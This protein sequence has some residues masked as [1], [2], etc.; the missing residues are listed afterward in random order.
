MKARFL[1]SVSVLIVLAAIADKG[2]GYGWYPPPP[3]PPSAPSNL[4][5]TA[6]SSNQINLN[7]TD[8]SNN[9]ICF[10]IWRKIGSGG[11]W[12]WL[13]TVGANVHSYS[14]MNL[15]PSTTYY[16]KVRAYNYGGYSAYSNEANATT[17]NAPPVA[18]LS[19][20]PNAATVGWSVLLNGSAS[21]DPGGSITK[22]EWDFSYDSNTF[23]CDY[24]ETSSYHPDGIFDGKTHHA[25]DTCGYH[26]VML[27]VTDDVNSYG[28]CTAVAY[29]V[30][31]Y[32]VSQDGNDNNNG[33]SWDSA[34]ATIQHGI[35]SADSYDIV[36]VN[37][38]TYYE[39]V[40]FN[41]VRCT[42]TSIDPNNRN[43]VDATII[44]ANDSDANAVTFNSSEMQNSVLKGFTITGA[45]RGIYCE[46]SSPVIS[47]CIIRDN[48]TNG[49][50]G[51][52]CN[53]GSSPTV[54]N[55]FFS[56]N[57]A[58]Y[59]GGICD[60]N[61]SPV[62]KNCVFNNNAA[63]ANGGAVYGEQSRIELTNCTIT[64]NSAIDGG[65][66]YNSESTFV[67][68]NCIIWGNSV[69]GNGNSIYNHG[70]GALLFDGVDDYVHAPYIDA[71]QM[72]VFTYEAWVYPTT[73]TTSG[74]GGMIMG[75]G[76]DAS[77]DHQGPMLYVS[78]SYSTWGNGWTMLY[79]DMYDTEVI[80][81][82]NSYP[83]IN[84]WSHVAVTRASNGQFN[85]YVNGSLLHQCDS[86]PTPALD[87][88]QEFTIGAIWQNYGQM[89]HGNFWAGAI[90]EV[91]IWDIARTPEEIAA[92]YNRAVDPNSTGLIGYWNFNDGSGSTA[93][94]L[95]GGN[96]ATLGLNG[97]GNDLPVWLT[98]VI[99][100][101]DIEGCGGSS[102]WD[103]NFGTDGG[104]NKDIDP[105]FATNDYHLR[106]NS[107]CINAGDPNG[108]YTG[109]TDI[110]GDPRLIGSNVDIGAD[111][112]TG[113]YYVSKSGNDNNNGL[114]WAEAFA[115]MQKGINTAVNGQTVMI[116][117]G[118]Y[119][120]NNI[121][122]NSKRIC[123][124]STDPNDSDVVAATIINAN[125]TSKDVIKFSGTENANS[126]LDGVTLRRGR[127]GI[128]CSSTGLP[129][130]TH[131][132]ILNNN[133]YGVYVTGKITLTN[134]VIAKNKNYG[135]HLDS[136]MARDS[137]I[138]NCTI[139]NN[140]SSG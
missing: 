105:N 23:N 96:D 79:E 108:S 64:D 43:V 81:S 12:S 86:T 114:S 127:Y 90:D 60:V 136:T 6:V 133:S 76:E 57:S 19:V 35:D 102:G 24:Y 46:G 101:S 5:A 50:G 72:P 98:S 122:F 118:T 28:T 110:D 8:N 47:H 48:D 113:V 52:M 62:I 29:T 66:V 95:A 125:S 41:G 53:L 77:N 20:E 93:T 91:R 14:N 129:V 2:Y 94:D 84:Q 135:V 112:Y 119:D 137:I 140:A 27:K 132:R 56:G 78:P 88:H 39:A 37:E 21:Y 31:T 80:C 26:T 75:R 4:T 25:Y 55:C 45:G 134:T 63:D 68:T 82:K 10:E 65:G 58:G 87:C 40:D 131:C 126:I 33:L 139:Y 89:V 34:F 124:R 107:P 73:D 83:P 138:T 9:E 85:I 130:V 18:V 69:S 49:L 67:V 1:I 42:V 71:Y 70:S 116:A 59:G 115:T 61:S 3:P 111:E 11:T 92:N 99:S 100:Y 117:Q 13:T 22:Y 109:Q 30:Y 121:N 54:S 74:S 51:G 123:V 104:G 106:Y 17:L 97:T 15:T 38:G 32:Y 16:Y 7:W 44:D 128:N 103:P 120:Q 36:E